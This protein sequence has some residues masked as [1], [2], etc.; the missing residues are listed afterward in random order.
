[1]KNHIQFHFSAVTADPGRHRSQMRRCFYCGHLSHRSKSPPHKHNPN[2]HTTTLALVSLSPLPPPGRLPPTPALL[3]LRSPPSG[4][5]Q[6]RA[7][8]LSPHGGWGFTGAPPSLSSPPRPSLCSGTS[9]SRRPFG[10]LVLALSLR[11]CG[12]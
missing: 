10:F 5:S 3:S 7:V 12:S 8:S 9:G 2:T 1:M 11:H 6:R 4:G